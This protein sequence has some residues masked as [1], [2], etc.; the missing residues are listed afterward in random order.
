MFPMGGA[1]IVAIHMG[2]GD[3]EGAEHAFMTALVMTV[4]SAI[5]LTVAGMLFA[6]EIALLSGADKL[7][8]EMAQM[9][10][11][12]LFFYS[13]FSIPM[14]MSTCLAVFVRNDG[15]PGLAFAGMC[16]GAL[17]NIF[18]DWLF[19]FPLQMG[20]VGAAIASGA[21]Q[22]FSVIILFSH[23]V[24]KKGKLRIKAFPVKFSL[25]GKVC[26]RGLPETASQLTTPVT[27]LCYNIVLASLTGDIGISTFSVLSF[28]FSL[29]NAVFSGVAQG[30]HLYGGDALAG[31]MI[32][33]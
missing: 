22:V 27:A 24:L 1:T 25:M 29:A 32:K 5:V 15:S 8:R 6:K 13:A 19:I 16:I 10:A 3:E 20:I 2:R 30:I 17:T 31:R 28:I 21:G 33:K 14:L 18:L 9:A 7:S 4:L 12:H 11:E 26:K 23:F